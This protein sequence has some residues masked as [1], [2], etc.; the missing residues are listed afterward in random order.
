VEN[1]KPDLQGPKGLEKKKKAK[2]KKSIR[3]HPE[4]QKKEES[5]GWTAPTLER[6]SRKKS[7]AG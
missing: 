1:Q 3:R 6:E 7:K 4:K 2:T 5:E